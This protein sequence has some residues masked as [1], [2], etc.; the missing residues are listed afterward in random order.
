MLTVFKVLQIL[1]LLLCFA[2]A[3]GGKDERIN[4]TCQDLYKASGCLFLAA[5]MM[6]KIMEII[7]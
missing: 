6:P 1:V 7:G 3:I 4:Q 5:E 2:G